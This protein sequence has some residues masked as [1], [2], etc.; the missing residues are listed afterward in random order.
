MSF[1]AFVPT[2]LSENYSRCTRGQL[3]IHQKTRWRFRSYL[4]VVHGTRLHAPPLHD[5]PTSQQPSGIRRQRYTAARWQLERASIPYFNGAKVTFQRTT[6]VF[7]YDG[8]MGEET[9]TTQQLSN[10][11]YYAQ[12]CIAKIF[13]VF[14]TQVDQNQCY[15]L[16]LFT[17]SIGQQNLS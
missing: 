16:S 10:F 12:A 5:W 15:K 8:P 13:P 14:F 1:V 3:R 7:Y 17:D 2:S 11:D 4:G 9:S 6:I